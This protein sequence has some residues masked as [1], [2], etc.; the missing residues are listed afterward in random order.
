MASSSLIVT[1]SLLAAFS[2]L[3]PSAFANVIC[4]ELSNDLCAFSISSSGKR[5]LLESNLQGGVTKYTCRTSEVVVPNMSD[6]IETDECV[7]MCG[8]DRNTIGISSDALLEQSFR[9]KLCSDNCYNTCPNIV[10]LYSDLAAGEGASLPE[11]CKA[12]KG[13]RDRMMLGLQSDGAP[14]SIAPAPAHH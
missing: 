11:M 4:E 10:N 1:L 9:E 13:S 2:V 5:C 3:L 7:H 14:R 6:W 8:L 12:V